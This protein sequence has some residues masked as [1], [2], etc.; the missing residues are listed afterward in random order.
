[1]IRPHPINIFSGL[2]LMLLTA[3]S[4]SNAQSQNG[5]EV[6]NEIG[7]E[8]NTL[9][10]RLIPADFNYH[11]ANYALS[12]RRHFENVSLRCGIGG[13]QVFETVSVPD[14]DIL[15]T[16]PVNW[17]YLIEV[18]LG[19]EKSQNIGRKFFG[20]YGFDARV[21][22]Y[23]RD[24][25]A[26]NWNSGYMSGS[27]EIQNEYGFGPLVGLGF[28][29]SDRVSIWTESSWA[30][31]FREERRQNRK[32]PVNWDY[33][34]IPDTPWTNETAVRSEFFAPLILYLSWSW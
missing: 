17:S 2:A 24:S 25:E 4:S 8:L 33:P 7:Y 12:Y 5:K 10:R 13:Y 20:Y 19:L 11:S 27:E 31:W 28:R 29:F 9:I 1:M 3:M 32:R 23:H 16:D 26:A 30:L 15:N 34:S 18:R 22:R 6:K 21:G 14:Y